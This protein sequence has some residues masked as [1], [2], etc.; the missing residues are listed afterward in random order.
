MR[1]DNFEVM[2]KELIG[3][4]G[5]AMAKALEERLNSE[6]LGFG[7]IVRATHKNTCYKKP[8]GEVLVK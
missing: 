8:N 7:N 5:E 6:L 3:I 4:K 1:A 2:I